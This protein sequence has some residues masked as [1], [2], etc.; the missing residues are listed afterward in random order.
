[1]LRETVELDCFHLTSNTCSLEIL[2]TSKA[3]FT[4]PID[5]S[6]LGYPSN[7]DALTSGHV[8]VARG[9]NCTLNMQVFVNNQRLPANG[10]FPFIEK[11][12]HSTLGAEIWSKL[13]LCTSLHIPEKYP[14][15]AE[16]ADFSLSINRGIGNNSLKSTVLENMNVRPPD[17]IP[18]VSFDRLDIQLRFSLE[19]SQKKK[20]KLSPVNLSVSDEI[21]MEIPFSH[22]ENP[23]SQK[24]QSLNGDLSDISALTTLPFCSCSARL[25]ASLNF[26]PDDLSSLLV[27]QH[28]P[29][30]KKE[31]TILLHRRVNRKS[32]TKKRKEILQSNSIKY[33]NNVQSNIEL[34]LLT[35]ERE[36][37]LAQ[38]NPSFTKSGGT[39][40]DDK[41]LSNLIFNRNASLKRIFQRSNESNLLEND[42]IEK[43][44]CLL[45][46]V[47]LNLVIT[48]HVG[49]ELRA[50]SVIKQEKRHRK[51][52]LC[53][54]I[55]SIFTS[56]FP[57]LIA[58]NS[59]YLSTINHVFS[60]SLI[61]N[62]LSPNL[63]NKLLKIFSVHSIEEFQ[64][65][66]RQAPKIVDT[67]LWVMLQNKLYDPSNS[68]KI[69]LS[70]N[71]SA[72]A[73]SVRS[74]DPF[75]S[76]E[77]FEQSESDWSDIIGDGDQY[78]DSFDDVLANLNDP[79][80]L[81]DDQGQNLEIEEQL[82]L[83]ESPEFLIRN[84][85]F[86]LDISDEDAMLL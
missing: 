10:A 5:L 24:I 75:S 3:L 15:Q 37:P 48:G 84:D 14:L 65:M 43:N 69:W 83:E 12:G 49:R 51:A 57:W 13:S 39:E 1:M 35:N 22:G 4:S 27:A 18:H 41:L 78:Y 62:C 66:S 8:W 47:T 6:S 7:L 21:S 80:L 74:C 38:K 23:Q 70:N 29:L 46:E 82:L 33:Q 58:N 17:N 85:V 52:P 16:D 79:D 55:P 73:K 20:V 2:A 50:I 25:N 54:I 61:Q 40:V 26:Q 28:N 76:A 72:E 36:M 9:I 71:R 19:D 42:Y 11:L 34:D 81:N 77:M 63:R 68:R 59:Q 44:A 56:D 31:E 45:A 32:S 30:V 60:S 86:P 67:S 64:T 53:K